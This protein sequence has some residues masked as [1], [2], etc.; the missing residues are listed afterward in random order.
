MYECIIAFEWRLTWFRSN[1]RKIN[2][3]SAALKLWPS[4]CC[5]LVL[6]LNENLCFIVSTLNYSTILRWR[7]EINLFGFILNRRK[8][9]TCF[10]LH[11]LYWRSYLCLWI[12]ICIVS[13]SENKSYIFKKLIFDISSLCIV[14]KSNSH[15]VQK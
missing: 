7:K 12:G 5:A 6:N 11:S 3:N 8:N 13:A 10:S 2:T 14:I 4:F 1:E 15:W 9:E